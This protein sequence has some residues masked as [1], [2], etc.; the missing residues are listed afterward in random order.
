MNTTKSKGRRDPTKSESLR[1]PTGS[2]G[3]YKD[4]DVIS[5]DPELARIFEVAITLI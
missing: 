3:S 5:T 4:K 1:D 2:K